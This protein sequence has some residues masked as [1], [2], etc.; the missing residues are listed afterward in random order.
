MYSN[1]KKIVRQGCGESVG[2]WLI[3]WEEADGSRYLSLRGDSFS[4][5]YGPLTSAQ[6]A[7]YETLCEVFL[8]PDDWVAPEPL[9]DVEKLPVKI[10]TVD[11]KDI[12]LNGHRYRIHRWT[13]VVVTAYHP[14]ASRNDRD[15]FFF[16]LINTPGSVEYEA[17][18]Q[19]FDLNSVK[20]I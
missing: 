15:K 20:P 5:F 9:L 2:G 3:L 19:L 14:P 8:E 11:S 1:P 7:A 4:R 13:E 16:R 17:G 6:L 18:I 12:S 10:T